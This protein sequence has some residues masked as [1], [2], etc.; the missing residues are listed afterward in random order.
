[1]AD[2]LKQGPQIRTHPHYS[3][4]LLL[5]LAGAF[6]K[7]AQ[8]PFHFWLPSAMEGPAPVSAFLHSVTMVK[9]GVYL[10]LRMSPIL[11]HTTQW[12]FI[13]T[14]TGAVTMLVGAYLSVVQTDMK[15]LLA[16]TTVN[17]LGLLVFLTGLGTPLSIQAAITFLM[18]HAFYKGSLFMTAGVVDHETGSRDISVLRGLGRQMPL[19]AV[20]AL[21]AVLSMSGIPPFLGF[22]SKE[23]TYEALLGIGGL[24]LPL[25]AAAIA[26]NGLLIAA[27]G[28]FFI[29]PFWGRSRAGIPNSQR[30]P[31]TLWL[32][33]LVL[34]VVGGVVGLY[35]HI[36]D[37]SIIAPAVSAV[38]GRHVSTHTALW[39]GFNLLLLLS[40]I[41]LLC[42]V[43]LYFLS[44]LLAPQISAW[45]WM[46]LWGPNRWYFAL[47]DGVKRIAKWQTRLLQ[48]GYLRRYVVIITGT[49]VFLVSYTLL[50]RA[51]IHLR[52]NMTNIRFYELVIVCLMIAA[53]YI[54][55]RASLRLTAIVAMGVIGYSIALIFVDFGAPD[56]AMTQFVI[57]TMTVILF[58]LIIYRLPRYKRFASSKT[59]LAHGLL[60]A[61]SG[62]LMTVLVLAVLSVQRGSRLSDFFRENSL[63]MAHG[64]NIVNVIIVDFRGLDTLG[65]I[66]VLGLAGAGAYTLL[67]LYGEGK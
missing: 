20:A 52:F 51:H 48:N 30:I 27:S 56:L 25:V 4:I 18:T 14:A 15:R 3:A 42:G 8:T 16:Y 10:L 53:A 40:F 59:R 33:P 50:S 38:I 65:E 11:G 62:C 58:V 28:I 23:V 31:L 35:P 2:L 32:G 39:H 43:G 29:R 66:T 54:T 24:K 63:V 57:E 67:K 19:V 37:A 7:S 13:V 17:G 41:T 36:L 60:A 45:S 44:S 46:G 26:G 64:R 21:L 1:M 55:V 61:V 9:A 22:I 47:L 6:T 12:S 49:A 5:I 34:A